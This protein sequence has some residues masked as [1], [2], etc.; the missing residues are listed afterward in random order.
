[1]T[2][3]GVAR[4]NKPPGRS[5]SRICAKRA[6]GEAFH[7]IEGGHDVERPAREVDAVA[8]DIAGDDA[9]AALRGEAM[10]RIARIEEP[11][12]AEI[13]DQSGAQ[14]HLGTRRAED[15]PSSPDVAHTARGADA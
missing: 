2:Q 12:V 11:A 10:S 13:I 3:F 5:T 7:R 6:R 14:A 9:D 4:T 1:L 15:A 8:D